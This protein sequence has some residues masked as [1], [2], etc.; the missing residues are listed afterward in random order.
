MIFKRTLI[1]FFAY[2]ISTSF[3]YS[4]KYETRTVDRSQ[5]A[6]NE[7]FIMI[8]VTSDRGNS[9]YKVMS[10]NKE[11]PY[12]NVKDFMEQYLDLTSV[13][14]DTTSK[15][16]QGTMQPSG[17]IFWLDGKQSEYG[18]SAQGPSSEKIPQ[19][20]F[21]VQ[22]GSC[23]LRYDV[24]QKW[25]PL[26]TTWDYHS[27]YLSVIPEFK[28][29]SERKKIR[30]QEIELSNASKRE[31][32]TVKDIEPIKPDSLFRPE[33]KYHSSLRKYPNQNTGW[34]FNY[35]ANIDILRGTFQTGGPVTYDKGP[36]WNT[37]R[38]Y[39]VYRLRDQGWFHLMEVG[40]T[41]FEESNL[42]LPN[43]SGKNGFRFDS[44]EMVYGAGRI[45][46]NGRA[47][48]N[49]TVDLYRDGVY[50][51]TVV[52][53]KDGR[54]IFDGVIVNSSSRLVAKLYYPDGS[55]EIREIIL[56]DDNGMILPQGQFQERVFSAE[57][58]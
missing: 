31:K 44:R 30:E 48:Q 16:C 45:A 9:F 21:V 56:S 25:F 47:Q 39:W 42:I 46:V 32:E 4:Q 11:R 51:N 27:Y 58:A 40:D 3:L 33:L 55:E 14:C 2:L 52:T 13:T 15:H 23:W 54:Y 35:D 34:D 12:L 53:G 49:T 50:L 26:T 36:G 1:L 18:D 29:L 22:N 41:Y 8:T 7:A 28:L 5:A 38:P 37:G 6:L 24:W 17:N 20:A 43:I 57:T 10:D 19:D